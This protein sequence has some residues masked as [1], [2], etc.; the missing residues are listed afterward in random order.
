[1]N[2]FVSIVSNFQHQMKKNIYLFVDSN[3]NKVWTAVYGVCSG[4]H[5]A[6]LLKKRCQISNLCTEYF[7]V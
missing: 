1:M 7:V 4:A 3:K 2:C 6:V 5:S